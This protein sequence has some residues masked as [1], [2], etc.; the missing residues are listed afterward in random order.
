MLSSE[1]DLPIIRARFIKNSE[2]RD[3]DF[4]LDWFENDVPAIYK[5]GIVIFL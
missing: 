3:Y 2:S 1:F 4:N 5:A